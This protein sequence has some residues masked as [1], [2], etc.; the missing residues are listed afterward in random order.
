M[1]QAA[2]G[3]VTG[4]VWSAFFDIP[5]HR[6][7]HKFK[8]LHAIGQVGQVFAEGESRSFV[9]APGDLLFSRNSGQQPDHKPDQRGKK[10]DHRT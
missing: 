1:S 6:K 3:Q 9:I 5:D 10:P 2:C 4:Q 8:Y 7:P